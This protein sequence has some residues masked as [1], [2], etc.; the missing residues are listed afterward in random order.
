L[1]TTP[2]GEKTFRSFPPH[3]GHMVNESSVNFWTTSKG[4]PQSVHVYS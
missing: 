4:S 1:N 3:C 2:T